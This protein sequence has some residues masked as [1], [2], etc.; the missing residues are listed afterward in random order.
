MPPFV[1]FGEM[2]NGNAAGYLGTAYNPFVVEGGAGNGKG[3]KGSFRVRGIQLPTGFTLEELEDRDKL[4]KDFDST[5]RADDK[6]GDLV[7]GVDDFHQ[8]PMESLRSDKT[9]N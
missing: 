9:Q 7:D 8:Q 1:T 4:L 5:F 6:A 3:D 2:R